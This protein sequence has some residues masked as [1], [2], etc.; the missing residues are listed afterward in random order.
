MIPEGCQGFSERGVDSG[1]PVL[2][3]CGAVWI[4]FSMVL[5]YVF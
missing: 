1:G 5:P 4:I 2:K 3:L